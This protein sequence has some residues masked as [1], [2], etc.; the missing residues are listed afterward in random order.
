[1][2]S[3]ESLTNTD[4]E[5]AASETT[6][7][8]TR[9]DQ[10]FRGVLPAPLVTTL[11]RHFTGCAAPRLVITITPDGWWVAP[12]VPATAE[13][14]P[15]SGCFAMIPAA[16]WR[17][18]RYTHHARAYTYTITADALATAVTTTETTQ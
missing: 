9:P 7:P 5:T 16:D 13:S 3:Q 10:V 15:A 11:T 2:P 1:M 8:R 12:G 17:T 14:N 4:W 18:Y 6:R